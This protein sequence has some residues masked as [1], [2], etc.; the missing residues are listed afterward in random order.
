MA[1]C[2][3]EICISIA[4]VTVVIARLIKIWYSSTIRFARKYRLHLTLTIPILL[5]WLNFEMWSLLANTKKKGIWGNG[6]RNLNIGN[7]HFT[8]K[9]LYLL[10]GISPL[11]KQSFS[12]FSSSNTTRGHSASEPLTRVHPI[13]SHTTSWGLCPLILRRVAGPKHSTT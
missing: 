1:N 7:F 13:S 2:A 3:G 10:V 5:Y 12:G 4:T 8:F 11:K 9:F 6:F